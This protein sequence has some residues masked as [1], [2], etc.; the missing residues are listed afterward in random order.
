[1]KGKNTNVYIKKTHIEDVEYSEL[2]LEMQ[3]KF[4][5]DY[6]DENDFIT[7]EEGQGCADGFPIEIDRM[8]RVL[9]NM[10]IK[11]ATH[12]EMNYHCD[13]IGYEISAY[14]IKKATSEDIDKYHGIKKKKAEDAK[15]QEIEKLQKRI[16]E[17]ES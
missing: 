2:D 8:I 17:L 16:K 3:E 1:M 10:K 13:H 11:G 9:K 12:V 7:I 5:F 6:D 15:K 14:E 4:G